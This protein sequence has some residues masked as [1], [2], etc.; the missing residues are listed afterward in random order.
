MRNPKTLK[1]PQD[2][3]A[4]KAIIEW[5]YFNG[6][7]KDKGGNK[8]SYM[9]C[10][11]KADA[12]K[13]NLP[14]LPKRSF[15]TVYFSHSILANLKTKKAYTVIDYFDIISED[16]LSDSLLFVN[17]ANPLKGY[18]N[19]TIEEKKKFNYTIKN[20]NFCFNLV[21]MKKPLLEAG[22]GYIDLKS[23]GS[24][25]YSLSNLAT[26]GT[27]KIKGKDVKVTGKSWMDH[28]WA[29]A[30][31]NEKDK[32]TWFSIQLDNNIEIVCCEF[33]DGD[34]LSYLATISYNDNRQESTDNVIL[35]ETGIAWK[36]PMTKT[37]YPLSWK[38]EI[39]SK[40]IALDIKPLIKNQEVLFG[41][42]NYWEGPLDVTGTVKGKRVKGQGFL[43][44]VGYPKEV[45]D[46]KVFGK[47]I[48]KTIEEAASS[49]SRKRKSWFKYMLKKSQT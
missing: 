33:D 18:F 22:K 3:S 19:K 10:L 49:F 29:N 39:P 7:L 23:K 17:Y 38:I 28:Q 14:F 32:W 24:Y 26:E 4:H 16:S 15:D 40:R 5:W 6:H 13:V 25:Y 2:E 47:E 27:I 35:A 36:S 9:N 48:Q 43:E 1:F 45:S 46:I 21:A 11:F 41:A 20:E 12:K 8:Y 34:E 30:S 44:L 37:R 42:I 31:Y